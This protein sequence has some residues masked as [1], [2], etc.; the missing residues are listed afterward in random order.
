VHGGGQAIHMPSPSYFP[1]VASIGLLV[2][3]FGLIFSWWI[4]GLGVTVMLAGLFGWALEPSA[5]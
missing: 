4:A 5:E 2:L 3:G 1:L